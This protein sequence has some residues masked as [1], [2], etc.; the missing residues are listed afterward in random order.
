MRL[1]SFIII[2]ICSQTLLAQTEKQV[3]SYLYNLPVRKSPKALKKAIL[4]SGN[5]EENV[6]APSNN[7]KYSEHTFKGTILQPLLPKIG[8]ID[9]AKIYLSVG[10]LISPEGYSGNMKWLRF[11]YFSSDT[12]FL[13]ELFD[14]ACIELKP[15]SRNQSPTGHRTKNNEE[16]GKGISFNYINDS[17]NMRNISVSRVRYSS[18][19]QSF[20]IN[21]SASDN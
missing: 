11:E 4:K 19:K 17:N 18:G 14:I 1:F 8:R 10:K 16:I 7:F 13:N 9:S 21:Y 6:N 3:S 15:T 20:T 12:L 5:F 2:I